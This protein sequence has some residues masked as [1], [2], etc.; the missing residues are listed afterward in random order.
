MCGQKGKA[1]V[2][3]KSETSCERGNEY[4]RISCESEKK[5]KELQISCERGVEYKKNQKERKKKKIKKF[6]FSNFEQKIGRAHV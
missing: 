2:C 3:E 1:F 6:F 4:L 5:S